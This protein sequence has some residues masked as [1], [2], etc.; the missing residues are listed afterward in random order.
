MPVNQI[1]NASPVFDQAAQIVIDEMQTPE[2]LLLF[3]CD[4]SMEISN[5]LQASIDGEFNN[6][7]KNR[8][9]FVNMLSSVRRLKEQLY[10]IW[11]RASEE[12]ATAMA[13]VFRKLYSV[14]GSEMFT[15]LYGVSLLAFGFDT[16]KTGFFKGDNGL[17]RING[18]TMIYK[19]TDL[20]TSEEAANK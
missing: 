1:N 10:L 19:I 20:L 13:E 17:L 6:P 5:L 15:D 8:F 3:L 4:V 12:P 11:N 2:R 18:L 14:D 9:Y 16:I 7:D